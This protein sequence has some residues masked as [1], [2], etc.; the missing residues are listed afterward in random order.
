MYSFMENYDLDCFGLDR[1][2]KCFRNRQCMAFS[3]IWICADLL[4]KIVKNRSKM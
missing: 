3:E 1:R 2:G 4:V